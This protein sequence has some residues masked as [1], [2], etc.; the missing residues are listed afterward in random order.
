MKSASQLISEINSVFNAHCENVAGEHHKNRDGCWSIDFDCFNGTVT[1]RHD[2]YVLGYQSVR[3][4][5]LG[6]E[7]SRFLVKMRKHV[8]YYGKREKDEKF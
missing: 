2:G 8:Q 7:L 1:I 5:S 4:R 6:Q 3:G